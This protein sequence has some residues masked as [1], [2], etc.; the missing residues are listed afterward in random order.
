M[1]DVLESKRSIKK[2]LFELNPNC[3]YCNGKMQMDNC[4]AFNYVTIDHVVP[5]ASGGKNEEQNYVIA[6]HFCNQI[7]SNK[8][9]FRGFK[10][11]EESSLDYSR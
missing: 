11:K 8:F 3:S 9:E 6:C 10:V 5:V 4:E 1:S 2:K 7:K